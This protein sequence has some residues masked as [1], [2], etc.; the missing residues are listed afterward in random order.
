MKR[1][2]F[3]LIEL[4]V[5][6]AIIA[7]LAAILL[8]ALSSARER[9]KAIACVS[10]LKNTS[11]VATIYTNDNSSF[12]PAPA[13]TVHNPT[14]KVGEGM[15]W[16]CALMRGNYISSFMKPGTKN[17]NSWQA[18]AW[19][20][21]TGAYGCPGI[22]YLSLRSGTTVDWAAQVFGTPVNNNISASRPGT[23]ENPGWFLKSVTLDDGYKTTSYN[24]SNLVNNTR[25]GV[26]PDNRIWFC[27][28]GYADSTVT[29]IHQ[30]CTAYSFADGVT[31]YKFG[32]Q[33]PHGGK[34]NYATH[35]GSVET[36]SPHEM[37]G[38]YMPRQ[39]SA[40]GSYIQ[41]SVQ[42]SR[43]LVPDPETGGLCFLKTDCAYE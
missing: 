19:K 4:L 43:Y 3:T 34:T 1:K 39:G 18:G 7:I 36:R 16:P 38:V 29:E 11:H 25:G 15:I 32:M 6:I 41:F 21:L 27:D 24:D 10:N 17:L 12:W 33:A 26:G 22:G 31:A 20:G 14:N 2:T 9:A 35:A 30:R 5:V 42:V 40:T 8:P 23:C 37:G 13:T 28:S